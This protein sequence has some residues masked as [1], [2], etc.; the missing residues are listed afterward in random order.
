MLLTGRAPIVSQ[1]HMS[2]VAEQEQMTAAHH[3]RKQQFGQNQSNLFLYQCLDT[4][5]DK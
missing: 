2:N 1:R 3:T 4:R 5:C